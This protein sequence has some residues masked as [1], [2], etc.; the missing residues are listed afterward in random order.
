MKNRRRILRKIYFLMD[1]TLTSLL[2]IPTHNFIVGQT[3]P[4]HPFGS[5]HHASGSV[6][7]F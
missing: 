3:K 6:K 5:F 1:Q 2:M 4:K 7:L